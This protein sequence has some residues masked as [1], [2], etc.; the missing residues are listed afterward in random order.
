MA[1][2][3]PDP[4]AVWCAERQNPAICGVLFCGGL[5]GESWPTRITASQVDSTTMIVILV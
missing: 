5:L 1:S 2:V 3:P 4:P